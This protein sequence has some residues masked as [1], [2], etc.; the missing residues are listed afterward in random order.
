[1]TD[2]PF[3]CSCGA[4]KGRVHD[5]GPSLAQGTHARC[6]CRSC[7]AA[8][9]FAG[10]PDPQ[11]QGVTLYQTTPDKIRFDQGQDRLTVFSFGPKNLLRWRAGCCGDLMFNTLITPKFPFAAIRTSRL[12]DTAAL[13]PVRCT[14]FIPTDDGGHR[15]EGKFA[16]YAGTLS[17]T[18]RALVTGRWRQTP[19][20]DLSTGDPVSTVEVL[21]KDTRD[22]LLP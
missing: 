15:H 22:R 5:A 16:I 11:D 12:S 8:E 14:G 13:G 2:L 4:V 1:M 19:F 3:T 6:M 17:R 18:A 9:L 7:R 21:P 20:F 10:A